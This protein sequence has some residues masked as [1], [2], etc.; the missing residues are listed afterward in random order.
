MIPALFIAAAMQ[1][2][3]DAGWRKRVAASTQATHQMTV[4]SQYQNGYVPQSQPATTSNCGNPSCPQGCDASCVCVPD[5]DLSAPKAVPQRTRS[6]NSGS[7]ARPYDHTSGLSV[8]SF[9]PFAGDATTS[10]ATSAAT[11]IQTVAGGNATSVV[12]AFSQSDFNPMAVDLEI[13]NASPASPGLTVSQSEKPARSLMSY[14]DAYHSGG[15]FVLVIGSRAVAKTMLEVVDCP[16]A[17]EESLSSKP[18]GIYRV[19]EE[20]KEKKIS[21]WVNSSETASIPRATNPGA[22]GWQ[23]VCTPG[24]CRWIQVQ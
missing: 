2:D 4:H 16:V 19:F 3:V 23:K 10:A 17:F 21:P 9:N 18:S 6:G 20:C 1:V 24:G 22:G 12:P 8:L 13:D 11:T 14:A 7:N 5:G 15:E